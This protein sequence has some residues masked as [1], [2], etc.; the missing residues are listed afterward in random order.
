MAR[1]HLSQLAA[2]APCVWSSSRMRASL[3]AAGA[4]TTGCGSA[5]ATT[6]V[7]GSSIK[8]VRTEGGGGGGG[9]DLSKTEC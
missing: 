7:G 1:P 2:V 9:R 6:Q 8:C 5:A 3:T 4:P